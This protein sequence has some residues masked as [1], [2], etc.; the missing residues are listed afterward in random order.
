METFGAAGALRVFGCRLSVVS[1]LWS[2]ARDH[3]QPIT[4]NRQQSRCYPLPIADI[5]ADTPPPRL[6]L[7]QFGQRY[8]LPIP[9]LLM[10]VLLA[11][12]AVIE[13]LTPEQLASLPPAL[14]GL[15]EELYFALFVEGGFLMAQGTLVD[16][17]TRLRKRPPLWAVMVIGA[18]LVPFSIG[19]MDV[20]RLAF[21]SGGML[22]LLPLLVSLGGRFMVMWHMPGYTTTQKIAARA[23][24]SNRILTGLVLAVILTLLMITQDMHD[25]TFGGRSPLLVAGAIYFGVAAFDDW[26][27]RQ[28][29]FAERPRVLF[30]YDVID[31]N[32]FAPL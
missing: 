1:C 6:R 29:R 15:R 5:P 18:V 26:R 2:I 12:A 22:V 11:A 20:L 32:Y 3:R 19:T 25:W 14:F 27:V 10:A 30:R 16:I 31:I 24:I 21:Q 8:A 7:L 13:F 23:L 28:P 4:G 17:A 9:D